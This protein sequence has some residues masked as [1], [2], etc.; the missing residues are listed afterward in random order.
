ML[1]AARRI[2]LRWRK[3]WKLIR[4]TGSE[5]PRKISSHSYDVIKQFSEKNHLKVFLQIVN[6]IRI[7]EGIS[8]G[9][10]IICRRLVK[11]GLHGRIA[12]KKATLTATNT[13]R[14]YEWS[15]TQHYCSW[16]KFYGLFKA[17]LSCSTRNFGSIAGEDKAKPYV[18][19]RSFKPSN[20][21]LKH[22]ITFLETML[23][24]YIVQIEGILN[25]PR[26]NQMLVNY[27]VLTGKH[28][29]SLFCVICMNL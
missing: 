8:W 20:I 13:Q 1:G 14:R 15:M 22:V 21:M 7:S 19:I 18:L 2:F 25:R 11:R 9:D 23:G 3:S 28:L 26:L 10:W 29:I 24:I 6:I 12:K 27:A 17:N 5:R 16:W 4:K